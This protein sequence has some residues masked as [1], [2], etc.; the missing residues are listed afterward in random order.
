MTVKTVGTFWPHA[1]FVLT[2]STK[3]LT[4]DEIYAVTA[5]LLCLTGI[6]GESDVIDA[7]SPREVKMPNRDDVVQ[8][9]KE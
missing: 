2:A 8:H 7:E 4:R 1:I 9:I 6:I 5:Y 3:S